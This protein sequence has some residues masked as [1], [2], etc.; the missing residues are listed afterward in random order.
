MQLKVVS[1]KFEQENNQ[2][3]VVVVKWHH[4]AIVVLAAR[5]DSI[6]SQY[7]LNVAQSIKRQKK[8]GVMFITLLFIF[9]LKLGLGTSGKNYSSVLNVDRNDL[10]Y[11][12][13]D[14][15]KKDA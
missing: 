9:E 7:I 13:S 6:K 5:C 10:G 15:G 4:H 11:N 8:N 14:S 1:N 12:D 3:L 2:I